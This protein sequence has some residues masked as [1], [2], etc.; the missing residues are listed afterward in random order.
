M[1]HILVKVNDKIYAFLKRLI[2][3][4]ICIMSFMVFVQVIARFLGKPIAWSEELAT[5]MFSWL[6]YF[7]A[8][9][10]LR[11]DGHVAVKFFANQIKN[12][13]AH[14]LITIFGQLC[15]LAFAW[16]AT[17]LAA[18]MVVRFYGNDVRAMNISSLKMAYV[19][20]QVPLS[21]AVFGLFMLEKIVKTWQ[22]G[23]LEE[24]EA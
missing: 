15:I 21:E 19:F 1:Y 23:S 14:K 22:E 2:M 9:V 5:Y 10:V 24:G 3:L 11:N 4:L 12:P 13:T 16:T 7:G 8:A 18:Q 17:F 20:L 6:T